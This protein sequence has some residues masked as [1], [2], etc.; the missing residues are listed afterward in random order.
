MGGNVNSPD[1]IGMPS[2][3]RSLFS[4]C[5]QSV[6]RRPPSHSFSGALSAVHRYTDLLP[7]SKPENAILLPDV[8]MIG[9]RCISDELRKCDS[10]R[11]PPLRNSPVATFTSKEPKT[12]CS[13]IQ[14]GSP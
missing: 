10:L 14:I 9:Y 4:S 8:L 13:S 6:A 11:L 12:K 3:M 5:D 1:L 7:F 2:K